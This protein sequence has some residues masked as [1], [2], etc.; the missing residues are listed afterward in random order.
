MSGPQ[1]I[2]RV[3]T[4]EFLTLLAP[5]TRA[6]GVEPEFEGGDDVTRKKYIHTCQS[7]V[8]FHFMNGLKFIFMRYC[9]LC[10]I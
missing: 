6:S 8:V 10:L 2:V 9:L 3:T 7:A 5:F 1:I 4:F